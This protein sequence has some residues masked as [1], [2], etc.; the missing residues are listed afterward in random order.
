MT[1]FTGGGLKSK[2]AF[3]KSK[4]SMVF[5]ERIEGASG[6]K[7]NIKKITI[8]VFEHFPNFRLRIVAENLRNLKVRRTMICLSYKCKYHA[9]FSNFISRGF[10]AAAENCKNSFIMQISFL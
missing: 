2:K 7:K 6:V 4:K 10:P 5:L 3:K 8:L 1:K 9:Y